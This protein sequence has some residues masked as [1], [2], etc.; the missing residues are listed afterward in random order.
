MWLLLDADA[1]PATGWEGYDLMVNRTPPSN[2]R[3]TV[4]KNTGGWNWE[5]VGSAPIR[6]EGVHLHL[7]LPRA[8]LTIDGASG[9]YF[10][11]KWADHMPENGDLASWLDA[12]DC[13]PNGRF[14][15]RVAAAGPVAGPAE[16]ATAGPAAGSGGGEAGKTLVNPPARD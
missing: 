8:L 1:N 15:Y 7:E 9:R 3:A 13:A 10:D 14:K 5:I 4:E 12:G 11:F 16:G 2:G 6:W